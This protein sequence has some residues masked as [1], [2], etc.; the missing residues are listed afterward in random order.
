MTERGARYVSNSKNIRK[1]LFQKIKDS[2]PNCTFVKTEEEKTE[3]ETTHT[4]KKNSRHNAC[5]VSTTK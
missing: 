4:H 3:V 1:D 2:V 5:D